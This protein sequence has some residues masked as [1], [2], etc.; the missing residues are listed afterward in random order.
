M[1]IS[2]LENRV[3]HRILASA[4]IGSV[5]AVV[6]ELLDNACDA[7]AP[8]NHVYVEIDETSGGLQWIS[9]RDTGTGVAKEDRGLMA[10]NN[11]TSKITS[12]AD[13]ET[14]L[15]TNGFRGEA[16]YLIA[17]LAQQMEIT[18]RTKAD[19]VCE[20][21]HVGANG[22]TEGLIRKTPGPVGTAVKICGLFRCMPVRY[23]FMQKERKKTLQQV[24]DLVFAYAC[25]YKNISF[26]LKLVK[27]MANGSNQEI[28]NVTYNNTNDRMKFLRT[29]FGIRDP[30]CLYGISGEVAFKDAL[31]RVKAILPRGTDTVSS[32][33][34]MYRILNVNDRM[35][36]TKLNF[37]KVVTKM[38]NDSYSEYKLIAP[39]L[40]YF[41]LALP[42]G[43]VDVNIEPSKSDVLVKD[44][45]KL[46]EAV[47]GWLMQHIYDEHKE[48]LDK[49][50][51]ALK[52]SDL[53]DDNEM[54]DVSMIHSLNEVVQS[55]RSEAASSFG[56]PLDEP[57]ENEE[58]EMPMS[59]N[60]Q[61]YPH[62]LDPQP[63]TLSASMPLFVSEET[64]DNNENENEKAWSSMFDDTR[65]SSEENIT[66][67]S[68]D[69][70]QTHV[71]HV[72]ILNPCSMTSME[73][74]SR[75][76]DNE[77]DISEENPLHTPEKLNCLANPKFQVP[78]QMMPN[79]ATEDP[80][81]S[82]NSED[83]NHSE[84]LVLS[85]PRTGLGGFVT[86]SIDMSP[87]KSAKKKNKQTTKTIRITEMGQCLTNVKVNC[88]M[89]LTDYDVTSFEE[90]WAHRKG[91][92][93]GILREGLL[94]LYKKAEIPFSA[95][96]EIRLTG[97]G[98]AKWGPC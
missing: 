89:L 39:Q 60:S 68:S 1:P 52:M 49:P 53:I 32:S 41:E 51:S 70:D 80:A 6:K 71:T 54:E 21:W 69:K 87:S 7:C 88:K 84:E 13:L 97:I 73:V 72:S 45:E 31:I 92:P 93:S 19:S 57:S 86:H 91:F 77:H 27:V 36:D 46:T 15:C 8:Q 81:D 78:P 85:Q 16:L 64:D 59:E 90:S 40:W 10:L 4:G 5:V 48:Y 3:S 61:A 26:H 83:S 56:R 24:K 67:G 55:A 95:D 11:T 82:D 23:Q 38:I 79:V 58:L 20:S 14:R 75:P 18:T 17:Q 37:G 28:E 74:H 34:K 33:K 76:E 96:T 62:K 63:E 42:N 12:W 65:L 98:V 66:S 25:I 50:S 2:R 22:L 29:Q 94:D 43:F 44:E 30:K 47:K 9:V 35:I